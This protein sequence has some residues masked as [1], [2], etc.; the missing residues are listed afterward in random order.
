MNLPIK[1]DIYRKYVTVQERRTVRFLGTVNDLRFPIVGVVTLG[2]GFDMVM[3]Y[4]VNGESESH[5]EAWSLVPLKPE[6]HEQWRQMNIVT[7]EIHE[8]SWF[9]DQE[10]CMRKCFTN[11]VPCHI[12]WRT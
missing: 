4:A 8:G 6:Y 10:S 11:E 12:E 5:P 3:S 9:N 7:G 1:V 2:N